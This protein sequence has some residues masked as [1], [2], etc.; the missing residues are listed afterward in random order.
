MVDVN[1]VVKETLALRAYEQRVSN[2]TVIEALAS[3][4]PQV[5]ADAHQIKQVLLNLVINAEQAMLTTH[6]RGTLVVRTWHDPAKGG[7]ARDQRRRAGRPPEVQ[8]RIFDP[9]FTTKE[10]GKGTGLGLTSPTRSC[11]S[12]AGA[13]GSG[14]PGR[15]GLVLRGA[16]RRR[17]ARRR[18]APP[19]R[20]PPVS[21]DQ[22][23]RARAC[24]WWK[25]SRRWPR[26]WPRRSATPASWWIGR[27]TARRALTRL[28]EQSYDLIVCDLKMPRID[29][30]QFYRAMAAATPAWRAA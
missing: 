7:A 12:T 29:G 14:R 10:V 9:F 2:I 20:R 30:M 26:P 28:A 21:L 17:R 24:W 27:V 6:G 16:A 15:R 18:Q 23:S 25:T 13:S 5:F 11:R 22:R 8:S 4:L 19:R 3:G 1:Q